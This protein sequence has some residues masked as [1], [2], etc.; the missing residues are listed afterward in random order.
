[1]K[2][3]SRCFLAVAAVVMFLGFAPPSSRAEVTR[4]VITSRQDVLNGKPFG[5]AGPYEKLAGKVYFAIDPNNPRN[6]VIVDLD[7]A[8][9]DQQGKVGFSADIFI[10]RPKDPTKGNG[11]IFFDVPN[12]GHKALLSQFDF[13]KASGDPTTEEDFGDGMLLREGYTLVSIGWEFDLPRQPDL[14]L[15]NAPMATDNGKPITG[16]ITPGPWFI[17]E[18]EVDSYNYLSGEFTPTYQPLNLNDPTYRMTVRPALVSTPRLIPREAWRFGRMKDGTFVSDPNWVTV[19]G[20]FQP[21][22]VYQITYRSSN[23]PVAGVGFAAVRDLAS[24]V[25]YGKNSVLH[26]QYVYTYGSSQVGRWQRQFVYGGFTIDEQGRKAIDAL[27]IQ[28]GGTSVG[29]FNERWAQEDALGEYTQTKFPFRYEVTT[30]PI[31]GKRDGLGARIPAGLEPK[32]FLVN[33]ESE[34]WDRGRVSGELT[35]SIDGTEDLPDPPNVRVYL[36]AGAKHG[37]G[38]WPPADSGAQQLR[39]DPLD[40]RWA[41]RALLVDLDEWV[42][43]GI[44][45]PDSQVPRLSDHTAVAQSNIQFPDIPGVQW[46]Y[47]V[48]GGYRAD[49]PAGPLSVLPFI[50]P[51]VNSDGND[52]AGIRLPELAVPLGTYE[53]W[54]FRSESQ[55]EP[56]TLVSMAGSFIPFARTRA[57]R[58]RTHDPRPSIE[59]RYSGRDDYLQR[60]KAAA[61]KMVEERLLLPGDVKPVVDAAGQHWDWL[62]TP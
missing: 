5:A 49:L 55:G 44:A 15:L 6:K 56:N 20:G 59:E 21:G 50:V 40:Y 19:K 47:H 54:A 36:L 61:N 42:R 33:T 35:M 13:A 58:A 18:Q 17:P 31:T 25:K 29:S 43:K 52:I 2:S 39:V 28:T 37:S 60:V 23:P 22:M 62:M 46:P 4:I 38:S 11:V 27:F 41:Q 9:R 53:G 16:W 12:R 30:D 7:K 48:P 51:Q 26:G 14:V 32:I 1:M 57:D 8:T 10:L 45:P 34:Y 24:A 3:C